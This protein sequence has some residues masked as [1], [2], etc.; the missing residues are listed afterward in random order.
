LDYCRVLRTWKLDGQFSI[1][2]DLHITRNGV[3]GQVAYHF[4]QSFTIRNQGNTLTIQPTAIVCKGGPMEIDAA[5]LKDA[6]A[7]MF[8]Q[9]K[10]LEIELNAHRIVLETMKMTNTVPAMP[11]DDLLDKARKQPALLEKL[12]QKYKAL[13]DEFFSGIDQATALEVLRNWKPS[14]PTN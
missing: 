7:F 10:E 3:P 4:K 13:T 1:T 8:Q 14:G 9:L 5:K 12:E 6:I 11:W 2:Q